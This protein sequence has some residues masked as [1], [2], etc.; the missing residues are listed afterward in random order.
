[1]VGR[2]VPRRPRAENAAGFPCGPLSTGALALFGPKFAGDGAKGNGPC[3]SEA[4]RLRC[5]SI[6][7]EAGAQV[8]ILPG[9]LSENQPNLALTCTNVRRLG[10]SRSSTRSETT[11]ASPC[12]LPAARSLGEPRGPAARGG[13]RVTPATLSYDSGPPIRGAARPSRRAS[14]EWGS[15]TGPEMTAVGGS[16]AAPRSSL[17]E[18]PSTR[19]FSGMSS[20][21]CSSVHAATIVG[22]GPN[23]LPAGNPPMPVT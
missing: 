5:E 4:C 10:W 15:Q 8:R 3:W 11:R 12:P 21:G 18:S 13:A 19:P 7:P 17:P 23:P 20:G 22:L 9:A 14:I 1:M 16:Q 6:S 2:G